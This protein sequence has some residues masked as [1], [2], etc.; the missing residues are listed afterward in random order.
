MDYG[1]T[2]RSINVSSTRDPGGCASI[3]ATG[4][5]QPTLGRGKRKKAVEKGASMSRR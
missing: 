2:R 3:S 1:A 5:A 4:V